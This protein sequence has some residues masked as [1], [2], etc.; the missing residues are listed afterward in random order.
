MYVA[1]NE[2]RKDVRSINIDAFANDKNLK[3][4]R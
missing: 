2:T 4:F 3:C 1:Y